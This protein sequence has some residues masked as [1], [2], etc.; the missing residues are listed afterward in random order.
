MP[1]SKMILPTAVDNHIEPKNT[2]TIQ[3]IL[4]AGTRGTK[5]IAHRL[6]SHLD[7]A[8]FVRQEPCHRKAERRHR[9]LLLTGA[10]FVVV[11]CVWQARSNQHVQAAQCS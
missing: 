3:A 10:F 11:I 7:R 5:W 6:N 2:E 4:D 9:F 1:F 8:C